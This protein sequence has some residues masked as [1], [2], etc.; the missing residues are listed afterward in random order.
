MRTVFILECICRIGRVR[1]CVHVF[2]FAGMLLCPLATESLSWLI[3]V[4]QTSALYSLFSLCACPPL[5]ALNIVSALLVTH[6]YTNKVHTHTH[7]HWINY[8]QHRIH[9]IWPS[10]VH[11]AHIKTGS[12]L[13][14]GF[15][16][17]KQISSQ[18]DLLHGWCLMCCHRLKREIWLF[19]D[20]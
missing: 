15:M 1:V 11:R 3:I 17:A 16:W 7:T 10:E 19:Y 9:L 14:N 13:L 2:V 8:M 12:I 5:T 6:I 4:H 20:K 18:S